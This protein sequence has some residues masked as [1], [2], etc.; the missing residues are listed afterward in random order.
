MESRKRSKSTS[1]VRKS[2]YKTC[3]FVSKNCKSSKVKSFSQKVRFRFTPI[4]RGQIEVCFIDMN[5]VDRKRLCPQ[6]NRK[7]IEK[8]RKIQ[9]HR[10]A[11]HI[12]LPCVNLGPKQT[13]LDHNLTS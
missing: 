3:C 10:G 9:R 4:F 7:R 6:T 12:R 11:E 13:I 8:K 5:G 1:F 2:H